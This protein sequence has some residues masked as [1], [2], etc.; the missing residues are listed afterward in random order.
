MQERER[1]D[2]G[3]IV[4]AVNEVIEIPPG[5]IEPAPSFGT[6]IHTAFIAGMGK[7]NGK[8][9]IILEVTNVLSLEEI[10]QVAAMPTRRSTCCSSRWRATA[11]RPRST[12]S[13]CS[14]AATCSR[15][16]SAPTA[17]MSG[18]ATSSRAAACSIDAR[19]RQRQRATAEGGERNGAQ[20]HVDVVDVPPVSRHRPSVDVLFR[21]VAKS[22]GGNAI[23]VIMTGMGD[24]GANG[25]LEM[26]RAGAYT[27]AQDEHSC[28]VFGMPKEAIERGG[29]DEVAPLAELAGR[30]LSRAAR[31]R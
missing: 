15:T 27:F 20:Y 1:Q 2:V 18:R 13:R 8:F 10:E 12:R 5:E 6:R 25:L 17:P 28:V 4:D 9:V 14:V 19:G 31:P 7:V 23:G 22:A 26:K 16:A 11:C 24:D 3:V 21:S 30:I 29:V